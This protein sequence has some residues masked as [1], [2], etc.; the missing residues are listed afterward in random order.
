[1]KPGVNKNTTL[2]GS[3]RFV[4]VL[5]VFEI[6]KLT[7]YGWKPPKSLKYSR[8]YDLLGRPMIGGG[9]LCCRIVVAQQVDISIALFLLVVFLLPVPDL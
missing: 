9:D 8:M 4:H 7:T 2:A 1:M 5:A 3:H 6:Q